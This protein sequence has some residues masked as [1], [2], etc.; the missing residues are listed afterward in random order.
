VRGYG[1]ALVLAVLLHGGALAFLMFGLS[2]HERVMPPPVRE[3]VVQLV[4][5]PLV[6][7][8][9]PPVPPKPRPLPP[10][11]V[12][13]LPPPRE[14]PVLA[15]A[16]PVVASPVAPAPVVPAPPAPPPP[17]LPVSAPRFDAAYLDNPKPEYPLMARRNG[18]EGKVVLRVQV[19]AEGRAAEVQLHSSSG[20]SALDKAARSAVHNWRFVPA[21]QG[22][23]AV[24]A[25]VL[26]PV[27]F[28]LQD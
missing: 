20:S 14:A 7:P 25:W 24:A 23:Q 27:V 18:D 13:P 28:K 16:A 11:V 10:P 5:Q 22:T 3:V 4:A 6:T 2:S 21:R 8:P 1:P 9:A 12:K 15:T 17:P 26:V 19:T